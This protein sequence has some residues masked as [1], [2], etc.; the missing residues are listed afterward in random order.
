MS[1]LLSA[2]LVSCGHLATIPSGSSIAASYAEGSFKLK[3]RTYTG[4]LLVIN[5]V[6]SSRNSPRSQRHGTQ[7][8]PA[9]R[10]AGDDGEKMSRPYLPFNDR[11]S[12]PHDNNLFG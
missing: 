10:L 7:A 3:M 1:T 12:L 4:R 8:Y 9:E 6:L 5:D 11:K 2:A